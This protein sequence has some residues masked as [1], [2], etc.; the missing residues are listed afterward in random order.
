MTVARR[1]PVRAAVA[2]RAAM[3]LAA[4]KEDA[5]PPVTRRRALILSAAV[6]P[7]AAACTAPGQKPEAGTG[8][9]ADLSKVQQKVSVWGPTGSTVDTGRQAQVDLWNR[10]QPN[11]AAEITPAP[12]PSAQGVEGLQ[13]LF[14]A[15][16]AGSPPD[17]AYVDRFQFSALAVRKT[18]AA[19]D[20]K[21]KRDKYDLKRHFTPLLEEVTGIDGKTYGLPCTTDNRA[22]WWNKRG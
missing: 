10:Q 16:A 7:I 5:M 22:F 15:V 9:A 3:M 13:K 1:L 17:V 18:I 12:F 19:I 21:I 20:D 4:R 6:S 14:A 2:R 11:L 8:P